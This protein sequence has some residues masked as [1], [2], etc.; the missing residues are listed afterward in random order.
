MLH[1]FQSPYDI[2]TQTQKAYNASPQAHNYNQQQQYYPQQQ[3]QQQQQQFQHPQQFNAYQNQSVPQQFNPYTGSTALQSSQFPQQQQLQQY[4]QTQ[5][6]NN[7]PQ[8]Q[9]LNQ[10]KMNTLYQ[11]LS[12][13]VTTTFQP[14]SHIPQKEIQGSPIRYQQE[15]QYSATQQNPT[16][17]S[18]IN[19]N[20]Y[21]QNQSQI[22]IQKQNQNYS[23]NFN[24][25]QFPLYQSNIKF[26]NYQE[27]S[28]D[29]QFQATSTQN[30]DGLETM[31]IIGQGKFLKVQL[32]NRNW[33]APNKSKKF[34]QQFNYNFSHSEH[35]DNDSL[36]KQQFYSL[37]I[38]LA[39][40]EYNIE[41]AQQRLVNSQNF[42]LNVLMQ[43]LD[44]D[45]KGEL[46]PLEFKNILYSQFNIRDI[47]TNQIEFLFHSHSKNP[48]TYY[49]GSILNE[50]AKNLF[51]PQL[52]EINPAQLNPNV[53]KLDNQNLTL[54]KNVLQAHFDEIKFLQEFGKRVISNNFDFVE[55]FK[56]IDSNRNNVI[57]LK[58]FQNILR[59]YDTQLED[60]PGI[61]LFKRFSMYDPHT[62]NQIPAKDFRS[63]FQVANDSLSLNMQKKSKIDR[64]K[65]FQ[66]SNFSSN[67]KD[68]VTGELI[69][70]PLKADLKLPNQYQNYNPFCT[71]KLGQIQKSTQPHPSGGAKPTWREELRFQKHWETS[72]EVQ[73]SNK[74]DSGFTE[75]IGVIAIDLNSLGQKPFSQ[76]FVQPLVDPAFS[77]TQTMQKIGTINFR[78]TWI[79]KD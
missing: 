31:N 59:V 78:I 62:K 25:S 45:R 26:D 36:S 58:E 27:K 21:P 32:K 50:C 35:F 24:T 6:V 54:V 61:L 79:P 73:V 28:L 70:K 68:V 8:N 1:Q 30:Y 48:S 51:L 76:D 69:F 16:N 2:L 40:Y 22:Q 11:P 39:N 5:N 4:G 18:Q 23:S 71:V 72:L 65:A 56:E 46:F 9:N 41:M 34:N 47:T 75:Q 64:Q 42:N 12:Q 44:P 49:E 43:I 66:R 17:Y 55:V 38:E 13:N 77:Q 52:Q 37:L 7:N 33:G 74:E 19:Y 67:L 60:M 14:I 10:S 29:F 15:L 20:N 63:I 3:Q 53:Y 57:D